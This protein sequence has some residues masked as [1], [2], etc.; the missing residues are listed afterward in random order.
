MIPKKNYE[1]NENKNLIMKLNDLIHNNLLDS[2]IIQNF[3]DNS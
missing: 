3:K 1:K 2:S